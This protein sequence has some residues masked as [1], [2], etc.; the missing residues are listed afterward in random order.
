MVGGGGT[1]SREASGVAVRVWRCTASFSSRD[2]DGQQCRRSLRKAVRYGFRR[3]WVT[4]PQGDRKSRPFFPRAWVID[5]GR[6]SI[7]YHDPWNLPITHDKG[8]LRKADFA[9]LT[10]SIAAV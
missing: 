9:G 8:N 1:C 2:C 3:G 6:T 4:N 10:I 7:S 5:L